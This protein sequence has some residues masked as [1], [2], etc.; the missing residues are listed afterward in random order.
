MKKIRLF[1]LIILFIVLTGCGAEQISGS[2][3]LSAA[4]G[5]V[6]PQTEFEMP[7]TYIID[8]ESKQVYVDHHHDS[9]GMT[10]EEIIENA[11]ELPVYEEPLYEITSLN[12]T[13]EEIILEYEEE[14]VEFTALSDSYFETEDGTRYVIEHGS[15]LEDYKN[16]LMKE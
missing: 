16:Q 8:T 3:K 7:H 2:F 6:N 14:Q 9:S 4:P 5:Y 1:P 15:T 10:P 12:A 13:N 11:E